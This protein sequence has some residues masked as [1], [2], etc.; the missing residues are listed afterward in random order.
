MDNFDG[1][2]LHEH[3]MPLFFLERVLLAGVF[4]R[5]LRP[6]HLLL[7]YGVAIH[8]LVDLV[9]ELVIN[10]FPVFAMGL[11]NSV[12]NVEPVEVLSL[13]LAHRFGLELLDVNFIE[14]VL[15]EGF[16]LLLSSIHNKRSGLSACWIR[17]WDRCIIKVVNI[18]AIMMSFILFVH[19]KIMVL[20]DDLITENKQIFLSPLQL[21]LYFFYMLLRQTDK[22]PNVRF[23]I[24][25]PTDRLN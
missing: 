3:R 7:D 19:E 5:T 24:R 8:T 4:L 16:H 21:V 14:N 17:F 2:R 6:P 25:V 23:S 1:G 15:F 22:F 11:L 20:M 18:V 13:L 12:E 9:V 10:P